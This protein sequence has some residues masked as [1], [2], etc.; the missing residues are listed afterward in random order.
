MLLPA[1]M[2]NGHL[3]GWIR[4]KHRPRGERMTNS[5]RNRMALAAG[6]SALALLAAAPA[7][8]QKSTPAP[9]ADA[10]ADGGDTI[11]VTGIRA[12]LA[13]AQNIKK[14]APT[15]VE[16]VS[17]EDIG[18]LP[19]VSIADSLARLPGVTAQRLEG[20]DQRLS[21]RGLGP[22]FGTTLLNGR[23]Q[24]T[25]GD[26]RGVEYDQY[27]SE[28]F[29]N[30]VVYKSAN[31]A[32]VPSGVSGTVDLRMIRP[33]A[34][35][36]TVAVQLR[37]Q[38]N[39]QK[40]LNPEIKRT[41]YRASATLIQ[42]LA[43]DTVGI[44]I[45][46]STMS[47]PTQ[48]ERYNAWGFPNSTSTAN[49]LL[50]GGAKPYVESSRLDRTG[51]VGTLEFQPS[52]SWHLT[53]DALYSKFKETQYLRGIEFPIAPDWGSGA[54]VTNYTASNGFVTSATVTGVEG[55]VRNDYNRRNADNYSFGANNV[56][57][58]SDHIRFTVDGS[59]SH[60]KRTDFLLEN[61]SGTGYA[62]TG[63]KDTLKISQNPNGT[64][65]IVP[66]LDYGSTSNL[67]ITD[68]RGWG[69]N[70]TESVVQAGFINQPQFKDDLKAL[71]ASLDGDLGGFFNKW[72]V[73]AVYSRRS[74]TSTYTSAFLCPK[75][76]NP[77]CTVS[78]GTATS[79]PIPAAAVVGT[80]PLAYLGVPRMIALNPLYLYNNVYDKAF[81]NRPDSLA[82]DYNVTEKVLTG[83]AQLTIDST[84]GSVPVTGSVGAQIVHTDQ[85]STGLTSSFAA[86]PP[87][88]VTVAG[89][90]G[91]EKY[92]NF[93]PTAALSFQVVHSGFIKLGVGQTMVRPRLD[94]ERVTSVVSFDASNIGRYDPALHPVF[95]AYGGNAKLKPYK[96][97]NVD[98]SAEYYFSKSGYISF[99]GFYKRL[100]DY[101]DPNRS[102]AFDFAPYAAV[103]DAATRAA[104]AGKTVG[105]VSGPANDGKG[106]IFGQE[107]TLSLPFANLTSSLDG[108]GFFGSLAHVKS[109]VRYASQPGAIDI[110]GL[111]KWVG[112]AEGYFE[113]DGFQARVSYRY[114]SK[115]LGEIAGLSAAPTFRT[116]KAEGILD[117]QVGYEFKDGWL[118]GLSVTAQAK[119]LTNRPFVTY[120]ANDTRRVIDYQRYGR[121]YY[122][123]LAYKF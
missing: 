1:P 25:V 95:S 17:A 102:F 66:T 123:T 69:Y 115:F 67:V 70:G 8:A 12:S 58:L 29:R 74:K 44:A 5:H 96:S 54:T 103:L 94:Q 93:L 32:V 120:E 110:P 62:T 76:S 59:W 39:S 80:V 106:H 75:D 21:I 117:A 56:L 60:S 45:G 57:N 20:R 92:T 4:S 40:S 22:D 71:R 116:A 90:N 13:A 7:Y 87:P 63:V 48:N 119:N 85:T 6:A 10:S 46:V 78:S 73:G 86:G 15:I 35:K 9:A 91:G 19:D 52:D 77:S 30:V 34:E 100:T 122:L 101:V 97:L 31:A 38:M 121:D 82:R 16:A 41:G 24:V 43:D 51:V 47:Q 18:K 61:Y 112:T 23:E 50:L 109:K 55:V 81:D 84:L 14:N 72:E 98:G 27:P 11:V 49:N 105:V 118:N 64:F 37:G 104:V 36:N 89:I 65:S 53:L 111:S 26:N 33:L 42:H 28:F 108:F 88:V 83:Y 68:P 107:A 114:R 113:K 79:I 2:P 3:K 99:S